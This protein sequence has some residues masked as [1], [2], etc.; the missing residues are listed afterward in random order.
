LVSTPQSGSDR[1]RRSGCAGAI[2]SRRWNR[3]PNLPPPAAPL[4]KTVE[5]HAM[6]VFV[7]YGYQPHELWVRALVLPMLSDL[8]VHTIDGQEILGKLIDVALRESIGTADA[9]IGF[10]Q[11]RTQ[12]PDGSWAPSDYVRQEIEIANGRGLGVIQVVETGVS[13]PGGMLGGLQ[14]LA[15]D[16]ATRDQFLVRLTHHVREW[17]QGEVY[18]RL[19]PPALVRDIEKDDLRA[20]GPCEYEIMHDGKVERKGQA[21]ILP[22]GGG[23]YVKLLG[24]RPGTYANLKILANRRR[25]STS[26]VPH[27]QP[28]MSVE[29]APPRP[30]RP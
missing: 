14:R 11:K 15:Y 24:F 12:N 16:E 3:S 8:G 13:P 18:L 25:W 22:L 17:I 1:F 2:R 27:S 26:G 23:M 9:L 6:R 21:P 28:F 30:G 7:A 20:P 5:I 29:L 4:G 19:T 10:L